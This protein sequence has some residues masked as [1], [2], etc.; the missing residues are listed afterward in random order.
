MN[1]SVKNNILRS[2]VSQLSS[3]RGDIIAA[4]RVDL[5]R[6]PHDD[7]VIF[8]RLKVD[9]RKI[10]AMIDAL[11]R[12][13]GVEDQEGKLISSYE[14]PDGLKIEN[15]R[16]PFGTVLIIFEARPDVC[17]EAGAIAVKAG[18][19]ILLKGGKEA[20][21]TN[22]VLTNLWQAA[23]AEHS[24]EMKLVRYLDLSRDEAQKLIAGELEHFDL[25]IPRGGK[26][27]IDL[28]TKHSP[29]PVLVSGRGNNFLYVDAE[30]NAEMALEIAADGKSRLSVCNALDKVLINRDLPELADFVRAL[31]ERF[32]KLGIEIFGDGEAVN[33]PDAGIRPI[34]NEAL[35]YEEFLSPKIVFG[36]VD[37]VDEAISRINKYSG[38]HSAAIVTGND[39]T[40]REF[41]NRVDCAA[42]AHNAST[43]FTDGGEFG[44]GAE[45]AI[46][47]QKLHARGPLGVEHL[48]TNKWFVRGSGHIRG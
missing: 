36:V 17:I 47:T 46:S 34:E 6:C 37:G 39:D 30:A 44:L 43:R 18:N 7:I 15:R 4:N 2:L 35:W 38:G 48:L 26:G 1:A 12:V 11:E 32:M 29:A 21:E 9:D 16:V 33:T 27:L 31:A 3:K 28:V 20:R 10:N 40:A 24:R 45:I 5:S 22:R 13:V 41:L 14:R 42:V 23:I 19:R 8:D 25:V